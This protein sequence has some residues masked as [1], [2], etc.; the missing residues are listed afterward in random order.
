M[1]IK[2][3]S[4]KVYKVEYAHHPF[5]MYG[6]DYDKLKE[7]IEE[8]GA[9][10]NELDSC[11]G[12]VTWEIS[13]EDFEKVIEYAKANNHSLTEDVERILKQ[14]DTSDGYLHLFWF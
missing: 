14:S 2:L 12:D 8:S 11:N 10:I 5:S 1:S 3:H 9:Y 6:D 13:V 7:L 4:A